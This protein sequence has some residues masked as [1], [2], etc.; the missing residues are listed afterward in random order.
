MIPGIGC[1]SARHL[2]DI[3]G[4]AEELFA[5]PKKELRRL[6]SN[7]DDIVEA[8]VNK[9]MMKAVD[10]ELRFAEVHNIRILYYTDRDYPQ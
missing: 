3:V 8:I 6:F 1:R 5:M 4:S 10:E 7:H 2:L 9:T